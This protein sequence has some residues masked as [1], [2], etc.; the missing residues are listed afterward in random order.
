MELGSPPQ[1]SR[2]GLARGSGGALRK[3]AIPWPPTHDLL[4]AGGMLAGYY[5]DLQR[6]AIGAI[7]PA[8]FA[9]GASIGSA[10]SWHL[11]TMP[12]ASVGMVLGVICGFIGHSPWLPERRRGSIYFLAAQLAIGAFAT[13]G[14]LLLLPDSGAHLSMVVMTVGMLAPATLMHGIRAPAH[15]HQERSGSR[16]PFRRGIFKPHLPAGAVERARSKILCGWTA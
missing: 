7:P 12:F 8:C 13:V 2:S 4:C 3:R 10:L 5:V 9:D 14:T 1:A 11:M 15:R 6:S 16:T